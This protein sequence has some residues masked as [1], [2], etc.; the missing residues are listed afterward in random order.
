MRSSWKSKFSPRV[1]SQSTGGRQGAG[2]AI[3]GPRLESNKPKLLYVWG[4]T[5][6][7]V[8]GTL[9]GREGARGYLQWLSCQTKMEIEIIIMEYSKRMELLHRWA[10]NAVF[11]TRGG[12]LGN[13]HV[14][15][16]EG[17]VVYVIPYCRVPIVLRPV[18]DRGEYIV[19]GAAFVLALMDGEIRGKLEQ[20][21]V[22]LREIRLV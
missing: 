6:E 18:G 8:L 19:V 16:Q 11:T 14:G 9:L 1:G 13:G 21:K 5:E 2:F 7:D 20:G 3:L 12:L 10:P 15:I 22:E 4:R 17:D